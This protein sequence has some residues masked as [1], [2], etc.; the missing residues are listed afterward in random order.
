MNS[1]A[2]DWQARR[3]VEGHVNFFI[4]EGL[5]LPDLSDEDFHQIATAAARLSCEDQRFVAFAAEVGVETGPLEPAE[6]SRLR[7]EIDARVAH[8]WELTAADF[9]VLL[10]DFTPDAVPDDYR[11]AL[12]HRLAELA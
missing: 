1:L 5:C 3:F 12:G 2:F 10:D 9:E 7:V 11:A 6:R 8:A 4:L